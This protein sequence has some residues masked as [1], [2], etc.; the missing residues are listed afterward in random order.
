MK[1][2]SAD[3][4]LFPHFVFL[5]MLQIAFQPELFLDLLIAILAI[6]FVYLLATRVLFVPWGLPRDDQLE[7]LELMQEEKARQARELLEE[8]KMLG[9]TVKQAKQNYMKRKIDASAYK[10]IVEDCQEQ[11]VQNEARI[12]LLGG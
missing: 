8:N 3:G 12:R 2:S 6:V 1:E 7:T 10:K 4:F 9:E 5:N 11:I